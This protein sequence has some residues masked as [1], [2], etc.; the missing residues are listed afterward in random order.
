MN[1]AYK[2][3]A[4][5]LVGAVML[6]AV[7][8]RTDVLQ[9]IAP[10]EPLQKVTAPRGWVLK[11]D[12]EN[13]KQGPYVAF[14]ADWSVTTGKLK[15]R[16]GVDY[17]DNMIIN[18]RTFPAGTTMRWQWP[19]GKPPSGVYGYLHIAY[20][21][22]A[23]GAPVQPVPPVQIANMPDVKTDFAVTIDGD[24]T[25]YN[26]LSE[27]FLTAKPA[28]FATRGLE[29]GFLPNVSA[30]GRSFFAGGEQLGEWR[31]PGGRTWKVA[32]RGKYCMLIPD[33]PT[34]TQGT[35]YFGAVIQ[36]LIDQGRLTGQEWFNGL[37]IGVEPVGGRGSLRVDKWRVYP[38][39]GA[40]A[41]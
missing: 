15:L 40:P 16:R 29:I 13:Y 39:L 37:A 21:N 35:L 10:S 31:D 27:T 8:N 28:Q 4:T 1:S 19:G 14:A 25:R 5:S 33:G 24:P 34:F 26:L 23:G 20:G 18:P 38:A 17:A 6:L 3:A 41:T 32:I 9:A 36:W 2:W 11:Q 30:D 7:T 22:Y 12:S